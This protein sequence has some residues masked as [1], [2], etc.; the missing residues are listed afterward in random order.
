MPRHNSVIVGCIYRHPNMQLNEFNEGFLSE[1]H[2]KLSKERK[3]YILL[4]GDFDIDLLKKD[5]NSDSANFLDI[6][7]SNSSM[8]LITYV[9]TLCPL[10]E[11]TPAPEH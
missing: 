7:F 6:M 3:K 5:E 1:L 8:L 4:L 2:I 10:H 9:I 11:K